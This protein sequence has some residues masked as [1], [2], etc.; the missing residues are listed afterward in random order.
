MSTEQ[1]A[2]FAGGCFW[3]VE[4]LFRSQPGVHDA[5]SGYMGG[6]IKNV[7][8]KE[9]CSG[10]TGHA[11]VVQVTFDPNVVS[12]KELCHLFWE[13]HDPTTLNRQGPDVGTQY[14]SAIY[15][16][17]DEQRI[18]AEASKAWAQEFFERPIVTEVTAAGEFYRAEEYH[19]RY[20]EKNGG[21]GCHV[22]RPFGRQLTPSDR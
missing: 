18:E 22:R 2:T 4:A 6:H 10:L 7:T 19:Q 13:I 12:F 11:E 20:F 3:G 1:K 16:H 17:S 14:R 15:F 8:Y 9:V 21:H 5:I